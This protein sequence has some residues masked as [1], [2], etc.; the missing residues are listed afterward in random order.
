MQHYEDELEVMMLHN[1]RG[2]KPKKVGAMLN[3]YTPF[4]MKTNTVEISSLKEDNSIRFHLGY[5]RCGLNI[6]AGEK[7][8]LVM[9]KELMR[10][11]HIHTIEDL[12]AEILRKVM[13]NS[14]REEREEVRAE[15]RHEEGEGRDE[16]YRRR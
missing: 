16:I 6:I 10:G 11:L 15:E 2:G 8:A 14:R 1:P 4:Q 7:R 5:C 12:E 9:I 13:G 3:S